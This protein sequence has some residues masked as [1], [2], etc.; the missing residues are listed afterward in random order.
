MS[1]S[2][3]SSE[4][5]KQLCALLGRLFIF[6]DLPIAFWFSGAFLFSKAGTLATSLCHA[7]AITVPMSGAKPSEGREE[8][9]QGL[10][11]PLGA[12]VPLIGEEVSLHVSFWTCQPCCHHSETLSHTRR[13]NRR[14]PWSCLSAP[15]T[16]FQTLGCLIPG[17]GI[18]E[19]EWSTPYQ[20][21]WT[22][23]SG[24]FS[25]CPPATVDFYI[26]LEMHLKY[27]KQL[28]L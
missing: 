7:L 14:L 13:K 17:W 24:L 23:S 4:V 15:D 12:T 25:L 11:P 18:P 10:A 21:S 8:K 19:G 20:F 6:H 27:L 16:L 26:K 22:F 9:Q 3:R 5:L 2:G 28:K 1:S